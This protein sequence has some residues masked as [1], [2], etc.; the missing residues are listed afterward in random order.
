MSIKKTSSSTSSMASSAQST[1]AYSSVTSSSQTEAISSASA[2]S[3]TIEVSSEGIIRTEAFRSAMS[4]SEVR[5]EKVRAI[6]EK[7]ANGQYF[8]DTKQLALN[9]LKSEV[10][11]LF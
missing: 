11:L 2:T 1:K 6:K 9:I 4:A 5:Q 7:L 3:D 10:E 8:I